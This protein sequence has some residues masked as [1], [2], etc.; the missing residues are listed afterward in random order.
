MRFNNGNKKGKT[1]IE[2]SIKTLGCGRSI[3]VDK[4][5]EIIS[6]HDVYEAAIK[7]GKKIIT[8]ETDG[9]VLVVVKRTDVVASE[10]KGLELSLVDN[11]SSEK[12]LNWDAD[13]LISTM[14]QNMSF[15]PR[16]WGGYEC[17]VKELNLEDLLRDDIKL[18]KKNKKD[19]NITIDTQLK[20]FD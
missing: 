18:K 16:K 5:G 7:L 4:N 6:G 14:Q 13:K 10:T 9:D 17:L 12:N 20:L 8:I 3:L 19:D 2:H 15:D 11:L 1:I